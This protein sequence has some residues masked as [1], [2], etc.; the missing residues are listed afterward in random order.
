ME[1]QIRTQR[2]EIASQRMHIQKFGAEINALKSGL[3]TL[4]EFERKLRVIA[5]LDHP[6]DQEGFFGVGAIP[7]DL[8]P[9]L[10]LDEKHNSLMRAMHEQVGHLKL[11]SLT[12]K[13]GF[14]SLLD[15][16]QDQRNLLASTPAIRPTEGWITSRFGKRASPFTGLGE[17]HKGLDLAA[18]PGTPIAATADGVVT[19]AGRKGLMGR[20]IIIDHGHGIVTRYG[21]IQKELKKRGEAVKRGETIALI[22]STGRSTGPHLHYEILLSGVPVNPEDYI[23]N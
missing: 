10:K 23:L 19:F 18:S 20:M 4:K 8:N 5:S 3:V 13:E 17:F 14:D 21:H 11:A 1:E 22:G 6:G 2:Q 16:L 7:E 12:Q 9:Q 15:R